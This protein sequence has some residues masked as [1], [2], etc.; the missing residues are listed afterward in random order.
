LKRAKPV[1]KLVALHPLQAVPTMWKVP[2]A[3]SKNKV[4]NYHA[5]AFC[6]R[7]LCFAE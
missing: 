1:E 4:C 2:N 6:A 5:A 7:Q 3:R